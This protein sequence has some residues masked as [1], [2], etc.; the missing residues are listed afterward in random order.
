MAK[1]ATLKTVPAA[2]QSAPAFTAH[3]MLEKE[4]SGAVRYMQVTSAESSTQF[5]VAEGAQIGTLYIRKAAFAK[6]K[7]PKRFSIDVHVTE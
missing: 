2:E 6:G 5:T 7:T 3:F 4:T 1:V